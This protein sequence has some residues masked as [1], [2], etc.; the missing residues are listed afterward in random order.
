MLTKQQ[1]V[2]MLS[3]RNI[4]EVSRRTGLGYTTLWHAK[5][6]GYGISYKTL[7]KLSEYFEGK[8]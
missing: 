5:Q 7:E 6:S 2:E 4:T 1:V 8:Q 3:D